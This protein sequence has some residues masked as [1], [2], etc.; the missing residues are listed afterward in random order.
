MAH[1]DTGH[2][3]ARDAARGSGDAGDA[4]RGTGDAANSIAG[5][6]AAPD[7]AGDEGRDAAHGT[8]ASVGEAGT[9]AAADT[10]HGDAGS[11]GERLASLEAE[12]ARL[13]AEL[14]NGRAGASTGEPGRRKPR[15]TAGG[16]IRSILSAVCLVLAGVL[17][18]V[19]IVGAWAA[20]QLTDTEAFVGTFAP[21]ADDPAV[22]R[23]V[24][25]QTVAAT[26]EAL[27]VEG[28]TSDVIDGIIDL[29][30]GERASDALRALEEP[31]AAGIRAL[32]RNTVEDFVASDAFSDIWREALRASHAEAL[33][34]LRHEPG[35]AVSLEGDELGIQLGPIVERAADALADAGLDFAAAIPAVDRTIVVAE[36]DSVAAVQLGYAVATIAGVWMPWLVLALAAAGVLLA[37][38]RARALIWAG[39]A[40]AIGAIVLAIGLGVGGMVAGGALDDAGVPADA[41]AALYGG[42]T[43][44]MLDTAVV[45]AVLGAAVALVAWLAGPFEV[46]RRMRG[47]ASDAAASL[48]E[49]AGQ[50]GLGTGAFGVWVERWRPWLLAAVGLAAA[51]VVVF[52]RPLSVALIVWTLVLAALAVAAIELVR[53][54]PAVE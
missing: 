12:N 37:H 28:L 32:I 14:G 44:R 48:R 18:P 1:D 29:G 26:E 6:E 43:A 40:L 33:A 27:D 10:P 50:R 36:G 9:G 53:R 24:A 19:A 20:T 21:L 4:A 7:G 15:R 11:A 46:P 30:T 45:V 54:P 41:A 42:V 49:A 34:A 35:A 51:L 17:T 38:K 8:A 23:L 3:S 52:A 25:A 39:V 5:G 22:Q 16:V 47:A 31:A 13:R 2:D